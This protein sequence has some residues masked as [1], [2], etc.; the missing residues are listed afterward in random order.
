MSNIK[1]KIIAT[2]GP[3]SSDKSIISQLI[4]DGV[5]VLRIN[6]S[7]FKTIKYFE[8][9]VKI[10]RQESRKQNRHIGVLVDL[11]GPKIRVDLNDINNKSIQIEKNKKYS[12]GFSK[13]NDLKINTDIKFGK[14]K[15]KKSF[16]KIDDGKISFE[17]TNKNNNSL[18]LK[19]LDNGLVKNRKGINFPGITLDVK[20]LTDKDKEDILLAIKNNVDWL[21]LSFV[22]Q[23]SDFDSI[24]KIFQ[25][26][27]KK[28]PI[29]AK[30]EKP[31]A[32]T[33]LDSIIKRFDGVLVA[34][35][36]LGVEVS[37][38]KL[39]G[40]Q[41]LIVE[42]CRK[43]KKPVIIATQM[44]ESMIDNSSPTRAEVNDVANAVY[45]GVDAVMLSGETA[46]G[47]YPLETVKIMRDILLNTEKEIY[48]NN[49]LNKISIE[50][51]RDVRSA[52]GESV[53]LI[54]KHLAIDAIVVMTESGSTA[55]IASHYRPDTDIFALTPNKK[56]CNKLSLVWGIYSILI[57]EYI[58]T[59]K[60]IRGAQ[61]IL[62]KNKLLKY[63][64]TFVLTA[65]I[66]V[67][68][69]GSTNM[70]KI[71]KVEKKI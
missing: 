53:K 15:S 48:K 36:D 70:L 39:P 69:T 60:M 30:I 64:N 49:D 34:R 38:S 65:G 28:I 43:F 67:G 42:Q 6:M 50:I 2:I 7:H 17:V 51:D 9:T 1:T 61:K 58:S 46:V 8:D 52:I 27:N 19:A 3:V 68:I 47:K 16:I 62:I 22:R 56:I 32:I 13:S 71:H 66:P 35:G 21:A 5:N 45:E 26:I 4:R 18:I 63:G 24:K 31:E 11:A 33:N 29:I 20:T 14:I 23:S 55:V 10:I 40:L 59:D 44:L 57:P 54:S 12:L 41:K 37:L 25:K